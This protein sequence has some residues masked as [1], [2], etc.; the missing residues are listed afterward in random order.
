VSWIHRDDVNGLFLLALDH[1]DAV[2]PINGTAP[3]PVRN[4]EFGRELARA[5]H[6]PFLPVGPPDFVLRI[7]LGEVARVVAEG[8]KILPAKAHALGYSFKF[9]ELRGALADLFA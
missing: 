6:R 4:R 7:A 8:Q 1:P 5:V 9:P 3:H 2:G